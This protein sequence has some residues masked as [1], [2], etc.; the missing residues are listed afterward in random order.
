[1]FRLGVITDEISRDVERAIKIAES[2]K[3]ECIE[4]RQCWNKNIKDL[5]DLEL[6]R[7]RR[8]AKNSGLEVVC[9]AS[10]LF[11]CNITKENKVKEHLN[12][13]GRL[14]EITKFFDAEILRGFAFWSI[15]NPD[16]YWDEIIERLREAADICRSEGVIY[17]LENEAA[18]FV[19]TG[20]D[21]EKAIKEVRSK[22]FR[23]TWD[24]GN[25]F[26]RGE[27]PYPDGYLKVRD[28][29]VHMHVKDAVIDKEKGKYM[30][31]AVGS[32]EINYK[33]QLEALIRDGY[34]GCLS[35]ETHYRLSGDGEKSTKES[36]TG[37][38]KMLRE[39]GIE[40]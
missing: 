27:K 37:L 36:L 20:S 26:C 3:L 29:I 12:F 11:K 28:Y 8:L 39:L 7:I 2:L 24:P 38:R 16:Q 23:A 33:G 40:L 18:T 13:L 6:R 22:S 30:F 14:I 17:A 31:V 4:L 5:S 32:G 19:A 10:P 34:N 1:M 25:A 21:A 15:K 9:I 35:I